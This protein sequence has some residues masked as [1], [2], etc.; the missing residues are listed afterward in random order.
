LYTK[1]LKFHDTSTLYIKEFWQL[2]NKLKFSIL[3]YG[4]HQPVNGINFNEHKMLLKFC[5]ILFQEC[6]LEKAKL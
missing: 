6:T 3:I 4:R 1:N 2:K 5:S